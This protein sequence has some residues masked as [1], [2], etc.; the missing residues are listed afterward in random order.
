MYVHTAIAALT[1]YHT[2]SQEAIKTAKK[3]EKKMATMSTKQLKKMT[4]DVQKVMDTSK[5]KKT[6]DNNFRSL[7]YKINGNLGV[8]LKL[9]GLTE[10]PVPRGG[11]TRTN[12]RGLR[13]KDRYNFEARIRPV[14]TK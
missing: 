13:K 6:N 3:L 14:S 4:S 9:P 12:R 8:D 2:E 5:E 11:V 10:L 1:I 7:L